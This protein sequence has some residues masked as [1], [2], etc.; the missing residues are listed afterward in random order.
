MRKRILWRGAGT[1]SDPR[2]QHL[3]AIVREMRRNPSRFAVFENRSSNAR[4][5]LPRQRVGYYR[6]HNPAPSRLR[7]KN[8][9]RIVVGR[10]GEVFITGDH[11]GDRGIG[12]RRVIGIPT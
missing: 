6:E 3:V 2:L 7:D 8:T 10:Q 1:L 11:Y 9:L 5:R 4:F 12:F